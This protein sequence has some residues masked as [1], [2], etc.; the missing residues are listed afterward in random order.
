MFGGGSGVDPRWEVMDTWRRHC[1]W[2]PS[3][4]KEELPDGQITVRARNP[5]GYQLKLAVTCMLGHAAKSI[6]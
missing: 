1:Y 4:C 3:G 6:Y 5:R 2:G